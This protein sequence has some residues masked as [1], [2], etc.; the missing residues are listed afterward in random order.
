MITSFAGT[1]FLYEALIRRFRPTRFLFGMKPP[2]PAD[3]RQS[4]DQAI[5]P[6]ST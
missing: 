5:R 6:L 3:P 1:L 4:A 2:Q